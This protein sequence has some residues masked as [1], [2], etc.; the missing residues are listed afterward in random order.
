MHAKECSLDSEF[1]VMACEVFL[2]D[3]SKLISCSFCTSPSSNIDNT[4][5]LSTTLEDITM[6]TPSIPSYLDMW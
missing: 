3:N 6:K 2:S 5:N 1:E 4:Y